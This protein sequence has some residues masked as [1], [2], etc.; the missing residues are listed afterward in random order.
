MSFLENPIREL[1]FGSMKNLF[2]GLITTPPYNYGSDLYNAG[3]PIITHFSLPL[4]S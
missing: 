2:L 4:L 3:L 1:E